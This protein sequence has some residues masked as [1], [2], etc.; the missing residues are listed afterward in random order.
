MYRLFLAALL[1]VAT[2]VQADQDPLTEMAVESFREAAAT[3]TSMDLEQQAKLMMQVKNGLS[4]TVTVPCRSPTKQ[5]S[6]ASLRASWLRL[7]PH[8]ARA[9]RNVKSWPLSCA[10][11]RKP[12]S[13]FSA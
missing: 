12:P 3:Q 9:P 13:R 10:I 2:C 8:S 7:M 5:Y 11:M 1:M 6:R 4:S